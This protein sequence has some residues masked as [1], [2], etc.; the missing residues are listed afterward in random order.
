MFAIYNNGRTSFR[1]TIDNLYEIKNTSAPQKTS[2]KPDDDSLFQDY[3]DKK[4]ENSMPKQKALNAYKKIA[5]M[6]TTDVVY[7]VKDVMTRDCIS[8]DSSASILEAYNILKERKVSQIPIT[9]NAKKILGLINKKIILNLIL[10]DL[11][12][13]NF[14]LNR[15]LDSLNLEELITTDPITDIRRVA[16]VM[17]DFRL[18]AIPV[19]DENDILVGIVSKTD[20]IKAVSHNPKLQLW[21]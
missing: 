12:N 18:D 1:S 21:Y 9:S 10:G 6:D 5:N 20:I 8:I 13:S 16:K 14:I 3:L 4:N 7:H 2:L 19:V 17:I 11:D 15:K